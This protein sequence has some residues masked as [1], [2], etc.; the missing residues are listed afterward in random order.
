MAI[1]KNKL[2]CYRGFLVDNM[3]VT[4]KGNVELCNGPFGKMKGYFLVQIKYGIATLLQSV[5]CESW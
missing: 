4:N 2:K 1:I 3:I 5:K